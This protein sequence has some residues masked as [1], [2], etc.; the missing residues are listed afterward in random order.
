MPDAVTALREAIETV[1]A[2]IPRGEL[3]VTS[4]RHL[5]DTAEAVCVT[6]EAAPLTTPRARNPSAQAARRQEER[7]KWA[8]IAKEAERDGRMVE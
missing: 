6:Q 5:L 1:R 3:T 7:R 2:Q 4:V 8:R